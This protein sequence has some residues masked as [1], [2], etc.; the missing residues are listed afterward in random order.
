LDEETGLYYYRARYYDPASGRFLSEDPIRFNGG[1]DFYSYA[2]GGPT[3]AID[4]FGTNAQ[5]ITYALE[6]IEGGLKR[7]AQSASKVLSR[8]GTGLLVVTYLLAPSSSNTENFEN[9]A[10]G[11]FE[12]QCQKN[13]GCRKAKRRNAKDI[14]GVPRSATPTA[15]GRYSEPGSGMVPTQWWEYVN[16]VGMTII[17]VEHPDQS[18]HVG[19]PKPQSTHHEGGKPKF[20]KL[21]NAPDHIPGGKDCD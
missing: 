11:R 3:N 9:S 13:E 10:E 4:P 8:A 2:D 16:N 14:A 6:V 17:I 5:P 21:P 19:T 15:Q 20:N 1:I 18:V 12:R 7:G